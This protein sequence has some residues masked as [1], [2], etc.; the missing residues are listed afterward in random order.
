M[1]RKQIYKNYVDKKRVPKD[2]KCRKVVEH[3][4]NQV[5][6]EPDAKGETSPGVSFALIS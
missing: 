5:C 2:V 1:R 4:F 6:P 3:L